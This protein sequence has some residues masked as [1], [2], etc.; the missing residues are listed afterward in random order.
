MSSGETHNI[1][2]NV[3]DRDGRVAEAQCRR[4][5]RTLARP[6]AHFQ[7]APHATTG[8]ARLAQS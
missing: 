7:P 6:V 4:G 1:S 3:A 5:V 2:Q 8:F